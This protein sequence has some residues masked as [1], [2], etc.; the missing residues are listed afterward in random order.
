MLQTA[1]AKR[2]MENEDDSGSSEDFDAVPLDFLFEL[3]PWLF[4]GLDGDAAAATTA[5]QDAQT[6]LLSPSSLSATASTPRFASFPTD[7]TASVSSVTP[8][9]II[10]APVA[11]PSALSTPEAVSL[12]PPIAPA[13]PRLAPGPPPSR[14]FV[15]ALTSSSIATPTR[16]SSSVDGPQPARKKAKPNKSTSQRQKEELT[17][18]RSKVEELEEHLSKIKSSSQ[19]KVGSGSDHP[20]IKSE[21]PSHVTEMLHGGTDSNHDVKP[22]GEDEEEEEDK[23]E[24]SLWERIAKRQQEEKTKAEVENMKLREMVEGQ[25][26]LVRSFERLL[27]KRQVRRSCVMLVVN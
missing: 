20:S 6:L 12:P 9:M 11:A 4:G 21:A 23:G 22:D 1:G 13:P 26:K 2:R 14:S 15:A 10:P 5:N 8:T 25:I 7:N 19:S 17:F 24:A 27:R 3:D 16:S 18:L